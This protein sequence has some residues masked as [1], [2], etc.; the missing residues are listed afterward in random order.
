MP[1]A[2]GEKPEDAARRFLQQHCYRCHGGGDEINGDVDF[3][4]I[5]S[6][7]DINAAFDQFETAVELIRA[8]QMPP[9]DEPQPSDAEKD[10]FI[11]WYAN[12]FIT[13]V[14]P[15]PG[16]FRPRRLSAHE[17]RNTLQSLLGFELNVA[18]I[19]AEQ[20]VSEKSLVMKLLP[21]DPPGP[22][23][24]TNDTSANPLTTIIW[25]QYS[26]LAD[27]GL[28]K[29]F[30][31]S[32]RTTL[33]AVT[34]PITDDF[35]SA[36]QAELLVRTFLKRANRRKISEDTLQRSLL[37]MKGLSGPELQNELRVQ[38]KSVLM[39]PTFLY[40]GLLLDVPSDSQQPVD[41]FELAE[42]LSY[43]IWADMPDEDLLAAAEAGRLRDP[44]ALTR[45]VDRLL[46]S[47]K[48][49]SLAEDFGVQWFSL[50]QI[51][52]TSNNPPIADALTTQPIDFL[53]Y[54]MTQGRPILELIDSDVTYINPHTSKFYPGD[55]NQMTRY[56]KEKGIE[57]ESVPNQ[58][59]RLTN[60]PERGGLL[61]MPGVLAM[62]RGPV[63]RGTWILERLLGDHL[64]EPPPD[65]GQVPGNPTGRKLTF[66]QRF[67]MHRSN[68]TCAVCHDRI[69]PLGFA[70]QQYDVAGA[71]KG[72][73]IKKKRKK[74]VDNRDDDPA[75]VDTSG[76]LPTGE[77]FDD[78]P[79][80]KQILITSRREQVIRTVTRQ[81][82]SYALCRK[83]Q[84]YDR[85]TV[86]EIVEDMV[87]HDGTFRDLIHQIVNS[88]PFQKTVAKSVKAE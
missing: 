44:T 4:S 78:F 50:K 11:G 8:R 36:E 51:E 71:F 25:D 45:Q 16:Y 40:R 72:Q 17:Y 38:L 21:T 52:K 35:L 24:F 28:D 81:M 49:R 27:N 33:E 43:F 14:E 63:Q 65:V 22:S 2:A 15:H 56:R 32:Q 64:P 46:A 34:G 86:E 74:K 83:L 9:G 1:C 57:V 61:T 85:P 18:I 62:N 42:R 87:K 13:S 76:R 70:L 88:L 59:I 79:G 12:R 41:Q 6:S 26:Y 47:P 20:T 80:L 73:G 66:R 10:L 39:S 5:N 3:A 67:E 30:S 48:S 19:E 7:D 37:P 53:H 29:L 60:T 82:L 58:Q 54:L 55:R 69:D 68:P 84:Y 75:I 23:G 77:T 31:K